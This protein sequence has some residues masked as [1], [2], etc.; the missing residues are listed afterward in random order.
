MTEQGKVLI[1]DGNNLLHRVYWTAEMISKTKSITKVFHIFLFLN[2]LKSY[3]ELFNPRKIIVCWDFREKVAENYRKILDE[4]YKAQRDEEKIQE[5]YVGMPIIIKLLES[6]GVTQINPK[7][8]EADDIIFWLSTQKYPN[9]S[10]VISAD[11]DMYQLISPRL[12]GNII[13]DPKKKREITSLYL[14]EHYNV[15]TGLEF[16]LQKALRGDKADNLSGIKGIR[17][18]RIQDILTILKINY[19]LDSLVESSLLKPE[20]LKTFKHNLL[21]MK[22]DLGFIPEDE[23]TWYEECLDKPRKPSKEEFTFLIKDLEFWNIYKKIDYWFKTFDRIDYGD[24]FQ[25][26]FD[27]KD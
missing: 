19:D 10:V 22:F 15:E 8:L 9:D 21:L 23:L 16:I 17:S 14:K 3:V 5:V 24:I 27:F 18:S 7:T 11:S 4:N 1:I 2:S 12:S 26:I 25:S 6:L 20:E 13:Y